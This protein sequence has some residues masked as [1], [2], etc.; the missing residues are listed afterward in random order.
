MQDFKFK[1]D[2]REK[3]KE[4]IRK[5]VELVDE[6]I[7]NGKGPLPP[8]M[9]G[10]GEGSKNIRNT[11][12]FLEEKYNFRIKPHFG[13]GN[14]DTKPS[15]AIFRND[16][17]G[18]NFINNFF[19]IKGKE[20]GKEPSLQSGIWVAFC[21]AWNREDESLFQLHFTFPGCAGEYWGDINESRCVSVNQME[22]DGIFYENDYEY[23]DYLE[24]IDDIVNDF[25]TILN[26]FRRYARDGFLKNN[27]PNQI[28]YGSPGTGKTYATID[29]VSN[30]PLNQIFYGPPGTGKTYATIDKALE[31]LKDDCDYEEIE[32][33]IKRANDDIDSRELKKKIFDKY[34]EKGQIE[35][36]TFHQSYGY[37]DF[38]EGIKP[39][40]NENLNSD[41]SNSISYEITDGIFKKIVSLAEENYNLSK[42]SFD[43]NGL[44][45]QY[46]NFVDEN[47]QNGEFVLKNQVTIK[48]VS[49]APSG[50][51]RSFELGGSIKSSQRLCFEMIKRDYQRFRRGEIKGPDDIQSRYESRSPRHGNAPYYF[52][53]FENMFDFEK[54]HYK[55]ASEKFLK[56]YILIIDEIN[57]GNVSKIFGELITLIEESKRIGE[58]EELKVTLPYSQESFGIPKNLYIIGTMNT[59]DRSITAL[60]T[61]LRRRFSFIE[62]MPDSSKLKEVGEGINLKDMLEK[63]NQR[64]EYLL[65]REKTIGH[66][67]FINVESLQDL[68]EVFQNKIIPLLQEYFYDD[69][70]KI[71]AVLND[72]EDDGMIEKIEIDN[73][74]ASGFDLGDKE[75]YR[76]KPFN[77]DIWNESETYKKIYENKE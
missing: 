14:L 76:V 6:C 15:I 10:T 50:S 62:M 31:I 33:T 12:K 53:L 36:I 74:F 43:L 4:A 1:S 77:D 40:I 49:R 67:Y 41:E 55:V 24:S 66:T 29:K 57:R 56:P 8:T 39:C 11:L 52:M 59:A 69:Y 32:S 51:F 47:L 20:K 17:L 64:I 61:A 68:K 23:E 13:S 38:V 34:K 70:K 54:K 37:E 58:S 60:D 45:E 22:E 30:I 46:A 72:N 3:I 28:S 19:K 21:Y 75:V 7:E 5:F 18:E 63:I 25:E 48:R 9:S 26:D 44:I 27:I 16:C 65:D 71:K 42:E 35:F 2:E 73:L